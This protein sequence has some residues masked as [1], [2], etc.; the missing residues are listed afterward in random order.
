LRKE[1][2]EQ[3]SHPELPITD[4]YQRAVAN[5]AAT[6]E[7]LRREAC[8]RRMVW[9]LGDPANATDTAKLSRHPIVVEAER[10]CRAAQW[11]GGTYP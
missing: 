1:V 10:I 4:E 2:H 5:S 6:Y 7:A 11:H 9:D 3:M 8:R